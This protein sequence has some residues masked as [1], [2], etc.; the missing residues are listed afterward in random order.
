M[1]IL[2]KVFVLSRGRTQIRFPILA[3][4][5]LIVLAGTRRRV[6]KENH[7]IKYF[8]PSLLWQPD[9]IGGLNGTVRPVTE[10]ELQCVLAQRQRQRDFGRC[11]AEMD[12]SCLLP[13]KTSHLPRLAI[14]QCFS[15]TLRLM[16]RIVAIA[17]AAMAAFDYFLLDGRNI[18]AVVA[19]L[20]NLIG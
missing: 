14:S 8:S 6:G 3:Y 10:Y 13:K 5:P 2:F 20:Y 11:A 18:H 7:A 4:G 17:L 15:T 12:V 19:L 1:V 9:M 16:F